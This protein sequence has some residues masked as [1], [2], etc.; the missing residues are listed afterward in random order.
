MKP[1]L[2]IFLFSISL[3]SAQP[4]CNALKLEGNMVRYEACKKTEESANGHFY[5]FSKEHQQIMD[6]AIAID[7][8]YAYPYWEK[9][10][11]YL[12]SGDFLTWKKLIDKVVELEPEEYLGYRGWCRYQFFRD[13]EGAI[14]DIELLDE[15]VDHEI[16]FAQNGSYHLNIAKALCYK[17]LD[18]KEKAL[19]IMEKQ[20]GLEDH[21]LGAYD[22]FHL[23]VLYLETGRIKEALIAFEKQ[24]EENP[25]AENN[26]YWSLAYKTENNF[27]ERVGKLEEAIALYEQQR[28]LYDNYTHQTDK[29]FLSEIQNELKTLENRNK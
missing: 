9:S 29:I 28:H 24:N 10:F 16:G 7:P 3:L 26:Y 14:A 25:L 27:N 12:K 6:E 15:M 2:Y 1:I 20:M 22:Y 19:E 17:A 11:A 4:N 23:G 8:T 13:Y 5:Q 21:F 18:Q